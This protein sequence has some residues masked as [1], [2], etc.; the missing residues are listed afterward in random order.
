[1]ECQTLEITLKPRLRLK[2]QGV[3]ESMKRTVKGQGGAGIVNPVGR[4]R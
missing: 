3:K 1:M 2:S 4:R